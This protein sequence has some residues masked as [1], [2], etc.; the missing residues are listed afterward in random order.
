MILH[1]EK[2]EVQK[3]P[4]RNKRLRESLYPDAQITRELVEKT[5]LRASISKHN[6]VL[7][8]RYLMLCYNIRTC[9]NR[10]EFT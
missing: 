10:V 3:K 8:V 6:R 9:E 5:G 1:A 4:S 2:P 7:A